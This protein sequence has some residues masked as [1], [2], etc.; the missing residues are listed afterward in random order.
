MSAA[1]DVR[2][3]TAVKAAY[4]AKFAPFVTWPPPTAESSS[5][6]VCVVGEDPFR[7]SLDE[8]VAGLSIDNRPYRVIRVD[9]IGPGSTC[10]IAYITGSSKQSV[11]NALN[12]VRGTPTLTVTDEGKT[13]GIINFKMQAGKVRFR[14]D[15]VAADTNGLILSSKLLSLA[16]SVKTDRGVIEP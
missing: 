4:L 16:L 13:A 2:L 12:A 15:K 11:E 14:I 5:F 1:A 8:A 7:A 9:T 3:A 6:S 10:D